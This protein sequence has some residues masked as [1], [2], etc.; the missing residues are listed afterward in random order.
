M[1]ELPKPMN[2]L[3]KRQGIFDWM[4]KRQAQETLIRTGGLT[5]DELAG[6]KKVLEDLNITPIEGRKS[7]ATESGSDGS[8]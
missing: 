5:E 1:P 2:V 4:D 3:D 6:A 8:K 7:D